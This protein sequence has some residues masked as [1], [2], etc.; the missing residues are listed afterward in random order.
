MIRG[1]EQDTSLGVILVLFGVLGAVSGGS[2][3]AQ[4]VTSTFAGWI[5]IAL[6]GVLLVLALALCMQ[7]SKPAKD[8]M[9]APSPCLRRDC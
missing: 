3:T 2:L 6:S 1:V 5:W 4:G 7:S 9:S 8:E